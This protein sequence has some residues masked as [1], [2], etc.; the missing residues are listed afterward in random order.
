VPSFPRH[1]SVLQGTPL[2]HLGAVVVTGSTDLQ[3]YEGEVVERISGSFAPLAQ[4]QSSCLLSSKFGVQV[5]G[6]ALFRTR[7]RVGRR[8]PQQGP[9]PCLS[10]V[11]V[12]PRKLSFAT[13]AAAHGCGL[14]FVLRAARVGTG[15]RLS[16]DRGVAVARHLAMVPAAVRSRSVTLKA[17]PRVAG[18]MDSAAAF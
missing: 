18:V 2:D 8:R 12:Q 16:R 13:T 4:W 1:S 14:A 5:P 15:W 11:R 10:L 9:D 7:F 6:G 3:R 17:T